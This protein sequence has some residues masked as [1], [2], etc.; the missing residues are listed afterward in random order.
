MC[1]PVLET[2]VMHSVMSCFSPQ[3]WVHSYSGGVPCVVMSLSFNGQHHACI[4]DVCV[5]FYGVMADHA[6]G[7]IEQTFIP[8]AAISS[9]GSRGPQ[10]N[11][12]VRAWGRATET[13]PW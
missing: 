9:A 5:A 7:I 8:S 6:R 3:E 10:S 1:Q 13:P 11:T 12:R 2:M 4:D